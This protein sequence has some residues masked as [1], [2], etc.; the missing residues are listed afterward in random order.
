MMRRPP[1]GYPSDHRFAAD[2][3]R[4]SFLGSQSFTDKDVCAPA[5]MRDCTALCERMVPFMRFLTKAVGLQW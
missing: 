5:F 2:L 3:M 4:K 1:A